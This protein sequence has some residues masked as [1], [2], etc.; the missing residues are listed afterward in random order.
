MRIRKLKCSFCGKSEDQI[1]KLVAGPKSFPGRSVYICNEC[2]AAAN[3]I[4]QAYPPPAPV[5]SL[6]LF[7]RL[8]ERL[9][10]FTRRHMLREA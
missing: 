8:S 3:S 10:R 1:A 2:V 7:H 5:V 9:R 6:P 4:M